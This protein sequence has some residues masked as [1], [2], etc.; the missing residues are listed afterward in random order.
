MVLDT[1]GLLCLIHLREAQHEKAISS[2]RAA[3]TPRLTH[4]YVLDEFFGLMPER[5]LSEALT[6]DRHFE[7]EGFVRVLV[8]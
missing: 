5:G 2:Y 4:S 1:S 6:I 8:P 7:Q 3:T